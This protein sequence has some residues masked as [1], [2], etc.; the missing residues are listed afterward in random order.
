MV[1]LL[2]KLRLVAYMLGVSL[3]FYAIGGNPIE[4]FLDSPFFRV[5]TGLVGLTILGVEIFRVSPPVRTVA[6]FITGTYMFLRA[7][8]TLFVAGQRAYEAG[9]LYAAYPFLGN[10]AMWIAAGIFAFVY[11]VVWLGTTGPEVAERIEKESL[12]SS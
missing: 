1:V 4:G 5:I 8:S 3:T 9:D 12:L 7:A 6:A 11:M 2:G 10:V